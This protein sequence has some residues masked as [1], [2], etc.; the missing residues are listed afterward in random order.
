MVKRN[1]YLRKLLSLKDQPLIKVLTGMRRVGKSTLLDLLEKSLKQDGVAANQ[2]IHLNFEWMRFDEIKDYR[3]LYTFLQEQMHGQSHVYLML[4][5]IQLVDHWERAINSIFAEGMADIYLTGS[6]AKLLSSEIATLLSGRYALI[7][8]Y[9]LSF[10]EYLDF[11]PEAERQQTDMAFQR[12]LQFGSLPVIPG[13]PQH[14]DTVQMV[15]S[16]IYNTVLMKDVIQRNAVR[17]PALLEYIVRFLADNVGNPVSTSKISGYL[18]SK[19][20]KTSALTVDNYLKMLEMHL[21]FIVPA[22]TT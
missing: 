8:V 3:Q 2:I 22:V 20:R 16:G 15:L 17:D 1:L 11:L 10:R 13:I 21:F 6:N 14:I 5:E 12:Y 9:P 18:T 19:G 4:D 7:E